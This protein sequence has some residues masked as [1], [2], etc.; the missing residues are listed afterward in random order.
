MAT[1]AQ[2]VTPESRGRVNLALSIL[3]HREP[4]AETCEAAIAALRGATVGDLLASHQQQHEV[5]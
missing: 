1:D 3:N 5:A 2:S 4:T